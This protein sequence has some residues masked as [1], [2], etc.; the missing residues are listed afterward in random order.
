MKYIISLFF[1]MF[2]AGCQTMTPP[3]G[4]AYDARVM[5]SVLQEKFENIPE[6]DGPVITVGIYNFMDKTGQ[7]KPNSNFSSL[8]SAVTQGAE[9]WVIQALQE[10][11]NGSW[12]RVVERIGLDNLVK[13]RQ[14]IRSTR[15]QFEDEKTRQLKPL[16]FAGILIEGGVVGYDSNVA[17]G[18]A[19]ARYLGIGLQTQ[20]RVDNVTV[21]MRVVSVSTGEVLATIS[22]E[23]TILS[24]SEGGSVFKFLDV[25]TRALEI[26]AGSTNNEPVNYAVKAA[27]EQAV[28]EII[29]LGS[30]KGLWNFKR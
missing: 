2:L 27:I 21:S 4:L 8:S 10:V 1:I 16:L 20:Y 30:E 14:L 17:T 9:V 6:L 26:E 22:T 5:T 25:G 24:T 29:L 19:G 15:E 13:E 18:G 3:E 23:K 7:R 11:G 12:F 28:V